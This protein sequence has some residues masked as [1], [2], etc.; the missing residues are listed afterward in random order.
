MKLADFFFFFLH[1]ELI[2]IIGEKN[3]QSIEYR[4]DGGTNESVVNE[5]YNNNEKS[6]S[7]AIEVE[8]KLKEKEQ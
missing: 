3:Q 2:E 7:K 6:I 1:K 5:K 8:Q 4:N